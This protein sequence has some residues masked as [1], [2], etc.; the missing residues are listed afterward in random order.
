MSVWIFL[1]GVVIE[2]QLGGWLETFEDSVNGS[3]C[4]E[5]C[6]GLWLVNGVQVAGLA[7]PMSIL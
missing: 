6:C 4:G 1:I 5:G 2:H 7:W 3:G